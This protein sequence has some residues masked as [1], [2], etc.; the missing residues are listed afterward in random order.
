ML[1]ELTA[2]MAALAFTLGSDST[3][4][5]SVGQI[6]ARRINTTGPD[7]RHGLATP[8]T[9]VQSPTGLYLPQDL[10]NT[11][12]PIGTEHTLLT[13]SWRDLHQTAPTWDDVASRFRS[14]GLERVLSTIGAISCVLNAF[15]KQEDIIE[16]QRQIIRVLFDDPNQV[17][18]DIEAW[19]VEH[20]ADGLPDIV[21][22]FHELQLI[23]AAKIALLSVPLQAERRMESL[24]QLG[25]ALIM[26]NDL[27]DHDA[28]HLPSDPSTRQEREQWI[29]YVVPNRLF[30]SSDN[31]MHAVARSSELY[32]TDHPHLRDKPNYIDL[33]GL[34]HRATGLSPELAQLMLVGVLANWT[35]C[36]PRSDP[37]PDPLDL[38]AFFVNLDI[39]DN[40][41]DAFRELVTIDAED[42]AAELRAQGCDEKNLHPYDPLPLGER[43]L[44]TIRGNAYCASV[45]LLKRKLTH[46]LHHVF[47]TKIPAEK[48]RSGYLN[49]VGHVFEDYAH[50]LLRRVFPQD[51]ERYIGPHDLESL[52]GSQR[53][54]CDGVV[55]YPDSIV[56]LETKATLFPLAVWAQGE[57]E[58]LRRKVRQIFVAA[59]KQF[60]ST[61]EFIESGG[62]RAIG[63]ES[64]R[65]TTYIPLVVMLEIFPNDRLL[66]EL[67]DDE[68]QEQ[69]ALTHAKARP[70]QAMEISELESLEAHLAAGGS[71][72]D[73]L[74]ERLDND[75]YRNSPLKN[76]LLASGQEDILAR[77]PYL[78]ER[79]RRLSDDAMEAFRLRKKNP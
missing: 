9:F 10:G 2:R 76:Y 12:K 74:R 50:R 7:S 13:V 68:V 57:T 21:V 72:G 44:V 61:I 78:G 26:V 31:Y 60:E 53:K 5:G 42:A 62:F 17:G 25:E 56:L 40:E 32:L 33:P 18:S 28:A 48:E 52:T 1:A 35:K 34:F 70:L 38:D 20:A 73:L 47:L 29:R 77:S 67:I 14:Y 45:Q 19:R 59:A 23:V 66:Y 39:S 4:S 6:G 11:P 43:P 46:G 79:F 58:T 15:S 8:T 71:L 49:Y 36:D 75:S 41:H 55:L 51:A 16:R 27:I 54:V 37:A 65:V 3:R 69:N 64:D 30:N 22:L 24:H 63:V